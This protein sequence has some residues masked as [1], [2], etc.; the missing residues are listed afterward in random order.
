VYDGHNGD[1]AAH[2]TMLNMD[3]HLMR[4]LHTGNSVLASLVRTFCLLHVLL[5]PHPVALEYIL[6]STSMN[7]DVCAL[8]G[9][10]GQAL[11]ASNQKL[12]HCQECVIFGQQEMHHLHAGCFAADICIVRPR[13]TAQ[14]ASSGL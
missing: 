8:G 9:A 7:G 2:R 4:A 3:S 6:V 13:N 14:A 11:D 5:S 1:R 12:F 10:V